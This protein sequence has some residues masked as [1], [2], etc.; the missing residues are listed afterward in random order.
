MN[1]NKARNGRLIIVDPSLKDSRGHHYALTQA[2]ASSAVNSS[3]DV[4]VYA[5]RSA[6]AEIN[7]AGARIRRVFSRST[8]EYFTLIRKTD[9]MSLKDR[10]RY[11]AFAYIPAPLKKLLKRIRSKLVMTLNRVGLS[12]ARE[13]TCK[14]S[15]DLVNELLDALVDEKVSGGD[16]VLIHTADAVM[17]RAI[18][19]I[20]QKKFPLGEHPYYHLCT[21]YDEKIMPHTEKGISV[22]RVIKYFNLLNLINRKV[23]LYA[24]NELLAQSLSR[25]WGV[26]VGSLEIPVKKISFNKLES[27]HKNSILHVVYLG[28]AREEK[29]FHL[30]PRIIS[31]VLKRV[32]GKPRVRFSIQCSPQIVG[33]TAKI[34]AAIKK[35]RK[36]PVGI[37]HLIMTEQ[38]MQE[39][40]VMLDSA[41]VVLLCYQQ[42]NY[43]VRGSGIAVEAVVNG[44]NIIATPG[45]YPEWIAGE[46]G[47]SASG[48]K[49][50]AEAILKI[51][52]D[53]DEYAMKAQKRSE[54][55]FEETK[56]HEYVNKLIENENLAG[57]IDEKVGQMKSKGNMNPQVNGI[58]G[59]FAGECLGKGKGRVLFVKQDGF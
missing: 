39:Y 57:N 55:F 47:V 18:L 21:P 33:Y 38:S 32:D 24:E 19:Q 54:W 51:Y 3:V 9:R 20:I 52:G 46:A 35:L 59:F 28:A 49:E 30:L 2:V 10:L 11:A 37:V 8:Y 50:I 25:V 31:E 40:R 14:W 26:R 12:I 1:K 44:K 42:E 41:D 13:N 6:D 36:C 16:R 27:N 22:Q 5:N 4:L 53:R 43:R 58:A 7:I 15:G 56:P 34:E 23:F 17:Y 45:T 48:G 29:G